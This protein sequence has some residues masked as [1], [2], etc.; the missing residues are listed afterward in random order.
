MASIVQNIITV[1]ATRLG[2]VAGVEGVYQPK[3]DGGFPVRD[4]VIV[5]SHEDI[6]W[7]EDLSCPGNPPRIAWVLP[8]KVS[9]IISPDPDDTVSIAERANEF[10]VL[11]MDALTTPEAS[12]HQFGGNSIDA[13]LGPPITIEPGDDTVR[14]VGFVVR[15]TYRVE[16]TS[17]TTLA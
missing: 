7:D 12:W 17:Q 2:V 3:R 1:A 5:L 14:G 4:K 11:A 15:I 13:E 16:E 8:V 6:E 10:V 9:C